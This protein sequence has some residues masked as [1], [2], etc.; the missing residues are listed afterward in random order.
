MKPETRFRLNKVIPF[1]KTLE[2]TH[3]ESVQQLAIRGTS[4]LVLCVNGAFVSL[5]LKKDEKT[6]P[7][8][9]QA[10]KMECVEKA[11]GVSL[12][13]NPKNWNDI[14]TILKR[15]SQGIWDVEQR[16]SHQMAKGKS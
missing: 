3:Y 9:L 13:A 2:N 4:D 12:V 6:A 1:L 16:I 5:E 15:M 14:K 10:Y 7:D 11:G 8:K